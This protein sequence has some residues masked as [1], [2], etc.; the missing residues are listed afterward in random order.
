[1][2]RTHR[3]ALATVGVAVV[4]ALGWQ[5]RA[6]EA[7]P[8]TAGAT[9]PASAFPWARTP[10][11][12][13]ATPDPAPVALPTAPALVAFPSA[14]PAGKGFRADAQGGLVV[15]APM[16]LR[17]EELLGLHEGADLAA[18]VDAELAAL[19]A[20]AAARARE[21]IAQLDAYQLA[22]RATFPPGEA[23]LVPEEGLAQLDT[24]RAMRT[25]HFGAEAARRMFGEDEAVARRLLELMRDESDASLSMEQKAMRAQAKY[26][27][28]R[29]TPQR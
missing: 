20:A 1:M 6:R 26:D 22:Q 27:L 19:P 29:G 8:V 4:A 7:V 13:T 21:L 24:L 18:H 3:L 10:T 11:T 5:L 16:R 15:D 28:E 9:T 2:K 12:P 17:A 14:A 23:P 25:S